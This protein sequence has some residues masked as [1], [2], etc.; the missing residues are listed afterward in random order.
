MSIGQLAGGDIMWRLPAQLVMSAA[1]W[2]GLMGWYL[3]AL[4]DYIVP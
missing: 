4:P 3:T 1:R 2:S